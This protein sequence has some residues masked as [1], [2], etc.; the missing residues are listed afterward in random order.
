MSEYFGFYG[1]TSY[2]GDSFLPN[3]HTL[4]R[5]DEPASAVAQVQAVFAFAL[6]LSLYFCVLCN[7]WCR[8]RTIPISKAEV[9]RSIVHKRVLAHGLSH[10]FESEHE[11]DENCLKK[12]VFCCEDGKSCRLY[13]SV[14]RYCGR[15]RRILNMFPSSADSMKNS[16]RSDPKT[17]SQGDECECDDSKCKRNDTLSPLDQAEQ[18][19]ASATLA[20]EI[21]CPICLEP[22]KRGEE[23][24]WSQLRHCLHVYHFECI[25][26]WLFDGNM[27]CPVCRDR[28]WKRNYRHCN[29]LKVCTDCIHGKETTVDIMDARR[30]RF[31]EVHGLTLP[32]DSTQAGVSTFL[33]V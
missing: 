6:G 30:Y 4:D 1:E 33:E 14:A 21:T 23:V 25:T 27:Y 8:D 19:I 26:K 29:R 22:L 7:M 31:C 5:D 13:R 11:Q 18:G 15:R 2:H 24:A 16:N 32:T 9:E 10:R 12:H 17:L 28:Y 3:N 20:E